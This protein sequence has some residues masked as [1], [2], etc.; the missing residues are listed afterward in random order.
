MSLF[1]I[2]IM[3]IIF[4]FFFCSSLVKVDPMYFFL[5][6]TE[7]E[8][9]DNTMLLVSIYF[10]LTADLILMKNS[11]FFQTSKAN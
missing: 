6:S 3:F 4:N 7:L 1:H 11:T 8:I 2:M 5:S 10:V 9:C